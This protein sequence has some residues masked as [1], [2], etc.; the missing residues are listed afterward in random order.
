MFV[1]KTYLL[2]SEGKFQNQGDTC[3]FMHL[4]LKNSLK[5]NPV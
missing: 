2:F 3:W 5:I 4:L 1:R